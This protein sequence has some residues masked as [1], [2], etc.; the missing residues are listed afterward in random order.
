MRKIIFSILCILVFTSN[1]NAVSPDLAT[2]SK[3][4]LLADYNTGEIIYE[5]NIHERF[6]PASMTKMMTMLLILEQID[7]GNMSFDEQITISENASSMGGSQILL[8]T[9][10]VMSVHDLFKGVAVAS[11]NDAAVALSERAYGSEEEFVKAMNQKVSELGLKN[12][13]FKNVTG[14]D[15]ANHYSSAYDMFVIA[16]ELLKHEVITEFTSIYEDYLR[17]NTDKKFWLV[18][19][20]KLVRFYAGAD[21]LK[22]GYTD[23]ALYCLT[24]TAKRDN[25]RLIGV[26]F[27]ATTSV[28]R[29]DTM[30]KMLD[31]GFNN[32]DSEKL[33]SKDNHVHEIN[34]IKTEDITLKVYPKND[35]HTLNKKGT[36]KKNVTYD[37]DMDNI[38]FPIKANTKIGTIKILDNDV[39]VDEMDLVLDKDANK[40][41]IFTLFFRNMKNALSGEM[42]F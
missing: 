20:N 36:N 10:E 26:I 31:Y 2:D 15:V 40:V 16:R 30:T 11:G 33:L 25:L 32:Y 1:I 35:I 14:L 22:T 37:I 29:N 12:T 5:K 21:G 17:A 39:V 42:E 28:S 41:N 9:S 24:A 4:A 3:S 6:A 34:S 18:N 38:N 13:N 7:N 27:G 23:D 8:E 19:T